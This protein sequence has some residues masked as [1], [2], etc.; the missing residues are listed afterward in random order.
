MAW[1]RHLRVPFIIDLVLEK[2]VAFLLFCFSSAPIG[3]FGFHDVDVSLLLTH[4]HK[5]HTTTGLYVKP[6]PIPYCLLG[7][8][9]AIT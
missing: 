5:L 3:L 1:S 9:I 8:N 6:N 4:P 2:T 7:A